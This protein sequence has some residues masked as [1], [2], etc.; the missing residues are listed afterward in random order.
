M[1]GKAQAALKRAL[2]HADPLTAAMNSVAVVLASNTPFYPIYLYVVLGR[3]ATPAVLLTLAS[4]PFWCA[5]PML[6]RTSGVS[7]R[8]L[9]TVISVVNT[10]WC[11]VILG[12]DAGIPLFLIPCI[13]L[14]TLGFHRSERGLVLGLTALTFLAYGVLRYAPVG[15]LLHL[16]AAQNWTLVTLNGFSVACLCAFLGFCFAGA[17]PTAL[18]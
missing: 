9:L 11:T 13:M 12:F 15:P 1:I 8:V 17:R 2:D 10:M 7:A 14:A 3:D 6:A 5:V 4:L 18:R 16:D